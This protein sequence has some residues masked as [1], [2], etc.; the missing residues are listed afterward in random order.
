MTGEGRSSTIASSSRLVPRLRVATPQTTGKI[1]PWFVP[2]LSA[3][4]ISSWEISCALQVALH[5]R[6]GDLGDLVHQLLAVLLGE[7]L[8]VLGDRDLAAVVARRRRRS[9]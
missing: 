7:R 3:V 9:S 6:V 8:H 2:S 4:T 1:P 5:Q